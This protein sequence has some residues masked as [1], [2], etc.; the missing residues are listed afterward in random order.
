M[1]KNLLKKKLNMLLIIYQ[2]KQS[3]QI[4]KKKALKKYSKKIWNSFYTN[5]KSFYILLLKY[6]IF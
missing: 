4:I 6:A 3:K 5:S 2:I 1:E